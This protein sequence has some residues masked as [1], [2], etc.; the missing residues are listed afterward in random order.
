MLLLRSSNL[1]LNSKNAKK[2]TFVETFDFIHFS[3]RSLA[4]RASSA[5]ISLSNFSSNSRKALFC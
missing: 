2:Y 4:A 5:L 1:F 3:L